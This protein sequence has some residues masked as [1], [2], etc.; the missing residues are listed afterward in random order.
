M[1]A[2][3]LLGG[4]SRDEAGGIG[5]RKC[6]PIKVQACQN[7]PYNVTSMPNLADHE[8]QTDAHLQLQTFAPLIQYGC[9]VSLKF[10]LCSVFTPMCSARWSKPI[11]PCRPLC[12][13]VRGRCLPVLQDFGFSWPHFLNCSKFPA[14]NAPQ[15]MCMEKP[16]FA[17]EV[18]MPPAR[19]GRHRFSS[20]NMNKLQMISTKL[21]KV[22]FG[23][24]ATEFDGVDGGDH[25][26]RKDRICSHLRNADSYIWV[27]RSRRCAL[28]CHAND[29][30]SMKEKEA[31]QIWMGVFSALCFCSSLFTV[32]TFLIDSSRFK[33]P[34]RPVVFLAMCYTVYSISYF[35]RLIGGREAIAC[36]D[37]GG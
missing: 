20:V 15:H 9:S 1:S 16:D 36:S 22:K 37:S 21:A 26:A 12:L 30:F 35:I 33:Y 10:F 23:R 8:E 14:Y 3:V 32:L 13:H 25:G 31:A 7:L 27:N 28:R 11:G 5:S 6:E 17:K 19:I 34:E 2:E 18:D 4:P 24:P 29:L